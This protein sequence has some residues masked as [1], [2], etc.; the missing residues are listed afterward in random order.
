MLE[1][2]FSKAVQKGFTIAGTEMDLFLTQT[3]PQKFR[4][5][6]PHCCTLCMGSYM[7]AVPGIITRWGGCARYLAQG[8]YRSTNRYSARKNTQEMR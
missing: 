7:K 5:V 2:P 8:S 4:N 3:G 6:P 1:M